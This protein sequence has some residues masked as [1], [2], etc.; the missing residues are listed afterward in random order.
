M[1]RSVGYKTLKKVDSELSTESN[2]QFFKYELNA[3]KKETTLEGVEF[4]MNQAC[5]G[6]VKN[7]SKSYPTRVSIPQCFFL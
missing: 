4:E 3:A 2:M 6:K 5:V 7:T 1:N